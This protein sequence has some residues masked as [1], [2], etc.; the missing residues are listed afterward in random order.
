MSEPEPFSGAASPTDTSIETLIIGGGLA[1]LTCARVL[2]DAGREFQILEATDRVGGRVRSDVVDGFTLDHG[3]QV[4]LTA[5]PA[6]QRWLDYDALRLRPF[7]PGALLR[8]RGVFRVLGDP[9]RRPMQLLGTALNPVGS[10]SDKLRIAKLRRQSMRGSLEDL[11]Q[12]S[13]TTSAERLKEDGF[14]ERMV[15]QFFRP[16]LGGVFLDESLSVSSR[17]LEFVFRMFASGDIAVPSDGM[18]AIPRQLA[19]QLPRGA[20]RFQTTVQSIATLSAGERE[21]FENQISSD[22][23]DEGAGRHL[24]HRVVLSDGTAIHC[25]HLVVAV[26]ADAAAKLLG[27]STLS[28]DWFGTTNLYYAMDRAP[29]NRS[30]L[31]LRGDESGPVQSAVVISNVAP[32]YAP[33]GKSLLSVSVDSGE[34]PADGLDDEALDVRVRTQLQR[35]FGDDAMR[36][37]LLRVFRV[38]YSLP[39]MSLDPILKSPALEDWQ[40]GGGQA[41]TGQSRLGQGGPGQGRAG[42]WLA[43]DHCQSPSIQGAMDSGQRAAE[44]LLLD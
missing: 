3:F 39:Q 37:R 40:D 31:M 44:Q 4:L 25:R 15:D 34:D 7:E 5:Y 2:A 27:L 42:V 41:S 8:Q 20:I 38:P 12:R 11:Y 1:G 43:G 23:N 29:D 36:W 21:H 30:L 18:A 33:P 35:W 17:M 22:G 14:S 24:R 13:A 10:I 9:W 19:D 16:F 6:C 32:T 26:P 28:R